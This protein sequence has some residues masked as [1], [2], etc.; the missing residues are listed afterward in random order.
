MAGDLSEVYPSGVNDIYGRLYRAYQKVS[1]GT[2]ATT[3][4]LLVLTNQQW[5]DYIDSLSD[6]VVRTYVK[7]GYYKVTADSR[8]TVR[9]DAFDKEPGVRA[10][11]WKGIPTIHERDLHWC[12]EN[13]NQREER[14]M[15]VQ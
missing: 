10:I 8:G 13:R 7:W 9:G 3:P 6:A 4:T 14:I 12:L 2:G 5:E 1:G 15:T 11:S